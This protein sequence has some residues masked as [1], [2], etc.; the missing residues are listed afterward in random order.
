ML[1]LF[2][3]FPRLGPLWALPNPNKVLSGLSDSMAPADI[4]ELSKSDELVFTATFER[5]A[6]GTGAVVLAGADP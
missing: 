5:R 2:V 3:F 1:L 6:A 4:A